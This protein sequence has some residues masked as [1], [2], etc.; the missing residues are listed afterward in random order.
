MTV[1]SEEKKPS[2]DDLD[3]IEA[4]IAYPDEGDYLDSYQNATVVA[5][6]GHSVTGFPNA[7][8]NSGGTTV[9][10]GEAVVVLA[11]H[12]GYSC[13]IVLSIDKAYWINS[14]YLQITENSQ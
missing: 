13:V 9:L 3:A 2:K 10:D 12:H 7:R 4:Q 1:A 14:E 11:E 8:H 6:H 5:P